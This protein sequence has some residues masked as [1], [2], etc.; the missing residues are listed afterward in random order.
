MYEVA[1][2]IDFAIGEGV[3]F[4]LWVLFMEGDGVLPAGAEVADAVVVVVVEFC[5]LFWKGFDW[6]EDELEGDF[7]DW[8]FGLG[9]DPA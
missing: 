7:Y 1:I 6:G 2:F 4:S 8:V 9:V 3:V 5:E